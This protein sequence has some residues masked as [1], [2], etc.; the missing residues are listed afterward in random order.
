MRARSEDAK[1]RKFHMILDTTAQLFTKHRQLETVATI[2]KAAKIAK[3]TVYLYFRTKEE[4][5]ME[6]S[7]AGFTRWHDGLRNFLL[8]QRPKLADFVTFQCRS[9]ADYTVFVDLVALASVVLEENLSVDY[10]RDARLRLRQQ[11]IRT[12]ELMSRTFPEISEQ[13]CQRRLRY[14]YTFGIGFWKECFPSVKVVEAM[15]EEFA[16]I[17]RKR[18]EFFRETLYINQL[19]W[20]LQ[21]PIN[22]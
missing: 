1:Q 6:L 21:H 20:G 17:E 10:V 4:I 22:T 3:G 2:A 11:T 5:Y 13:T 8:D 16:D 12:A 15:P 18:H 9:L 14:F 19:L 7:V